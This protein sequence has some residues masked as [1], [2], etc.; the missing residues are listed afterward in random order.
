MI[1]GSS[2]IIKKMGHARYLTMP[3]QAFREGEEFNPSTLPIRIDSRPRRT[4]AW[5]FFAIG[6]FF[7][8]GLIMIYIETIYD[9]GNSEE[10]WGRFMIFLTI[11]VAALL[12]A[13]A[14]AW[15]R[16]DVLEL[17]KERVRIER[18]GM[19]GTVSNQALLSEYQG[20]RASSRYIE[21]SEVTSGTT[22]W[23]IELVHNDPRL[24]ILL[25]CKS[26]DEPS[27]YSANPEPGDRRDWT[28]HMNLLARQWSHELDLPL[29]NI[30]IGR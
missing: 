27:E 10:S 5:T 26:R 2:K 16:T 23:E 22:H 14:M 29:L 30:E 9:L 28:D 13:G 8:F 25:F 21:D 19:F 11:L 1:S 24:C 17:K 20:I 6:G 7:L 3:I 4:L 12:F 18:H 15:K